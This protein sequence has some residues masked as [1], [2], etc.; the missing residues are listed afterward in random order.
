MTSSNDCCVTVKLLNTFINP[1]VRQYKTLK[2]AKNIVEIP[3]DIVLWLRSNPNSQDYTNQYKVLMKDD[4]YSIEL[5][6]SVTRHDTYRRDGAV[7]VTLIHN[8][9][10]LTDTGFVF[11]VM[12]D[13][14]ICNLLARK[15]GFTI[16]IILGYN[17]TELL[18]DAN[19][20]FKIKTDN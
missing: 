3:A 9:K 19:S 16:D 15:I 14:N 20:W 8:C 4:D 17:S 10:R 2:D 11:E 5:V 1:E 12:P 13:T 7:V 6:L 18:N